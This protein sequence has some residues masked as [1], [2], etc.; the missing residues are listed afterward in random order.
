MDRQLA[1]PTR[2]V[3]V[4]RPDLARQVEAILRRAG[5][6]VHRTPDVS[7]VAALVTRIRAHLVI[8]AQDIPWADPS[9]TP[10]RLADQFHWVPVLLIGGAGDDGEADN[11]PRLATPLDQR[12]LLVMVDQLMDSVDRKT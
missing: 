9:E 3:V 5:H 4:A 8:V 2:V 11:F 1:V 6:E 12:S 10:S 7:G